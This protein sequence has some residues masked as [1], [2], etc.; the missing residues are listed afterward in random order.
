MRLMPVLSLLLVACGPQ[1]VIEAAPV[2]PDVLLA[3]CP[4]WQGAV[5]TMQGML[6]EAIVAEKGGRLCANDKLASVARLVGPR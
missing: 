2:V 3:P 5:P 1:P 4:G 6:I